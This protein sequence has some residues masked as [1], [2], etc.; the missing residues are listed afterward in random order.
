MDAHAGLKKEAEEAAEA[1]SP[2]GGSAG[3][4][5]ATSLL[6]LWGNCAIN[7]SLKHP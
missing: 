5:A 7:C 4:A 6:T 1:A 3:E 2:A